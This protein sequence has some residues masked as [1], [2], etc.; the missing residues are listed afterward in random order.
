MENSISVYLY[1]GNKQL[2]VPSLQT[3]GRK[4]KLETSQ[5]GII[6]HYI[7]LKKQFTKMKNENEQIILSELNED[8]RKLMSVESYKIGDYTF[9]VKKRILSIGSEAVK[10]TRKETYLLVVFAG[11]I[12]IVL[13]RKDILVTVWMEDTYYK[14]RSMDVYLYKLRK[15]LSKD[16]KI[17]I[18]NIRTKGFR[19]F[20]S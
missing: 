20:V 10:L 4:K 1:V 19:L 15:L 17:N 6:Y 5:F 11:N 18:V 3:R 16:P 13:E 7:T 14:A 12:N 2:T 8:L 9:D